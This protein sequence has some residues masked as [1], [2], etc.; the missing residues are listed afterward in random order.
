VGREKRIAPGVFCKVGSAVSPTDSKGVGVLVMTPVEGALVAVL[1]VL[2]SSSVSLVV[3][4]ADRINI[5]MQIM[6]IRRT[7]DFMVAVSELGG[8]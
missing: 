4:H 7:K 5:N 6:K 2:I 1:D 8:V 3:A